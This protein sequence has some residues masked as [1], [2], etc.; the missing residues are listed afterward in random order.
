MA[1]AAVL[2]ATL[3]PSGCLPSSEGEITGERLFVPLLGFKPAYLRIDLEGQTGSGGF[4]VKYLDFSGQRVA[5]EV[6]GLP[7]HKNRWAGVLGHGSSKNRKSYYALKIE[8]FGEVKEP[9]KY[10]FAPLA[11]PGQRPLGLFDPEP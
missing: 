5:L 11:G 1:I 3:F 2:S 8:R 7:S 10:T 6:V 4:L 9:L